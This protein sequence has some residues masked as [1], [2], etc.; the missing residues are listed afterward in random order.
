[1][2]RPNS[3]HLQMQLLTTIDT[4]PK[5]QALRLQEGW[6]ATFYY[7]FFCRIDEQ[8]YAVLYSE[9]DSRPNIPVNVLVALEALK[10]G[11]NWS[12]EEIFDAFCFDL[13]V[14]FALGYRNLD[15][16]QFDLRTVY[17]FR[18]R[19]GEHMQKTGVN[20][21][22]KSFEQVTDEQID[23]FRLKTGR[24]RMDSSEIASNIRNMSRL[25]L[26]VEVI[27]RVHRMLNEDDRERYAQTFAPYT[28]GTSGQYVYRVKGEDGPAHMQRIGELMRELLEKLA[29]AYGEQTTYQMLQRVFAEHFLVEQDRLRL[30]VGKEL[31]AQSLNSPDD[32]EATFRKKNNRS[33]KGYVANVTETCDPDNPLQLIAKVQTKPNVANDDDMLVEAI[34]SLKERLGIEEVHTDGGYNSDESFKVLRDD[35]IELIQTAIRGHSPHEHLGLDKF[36]IATSAA[37]NTEEAGSDTLEDGSIG[38]SEPATGECNVANEPDPACGMAATSQYA[39]P[40]K[41]VPIK[42]TCP[43]GQTVEIDPVESKTEYKRYRAH[44]DTGQCAT[45]P[46]KDKCLAREVKSGRHRTLSFDERD[47]EIARRRRRIAQDQDAGTNLRVA[48]ESTIASLKQPFNYDQ[49]PVRGM[50]RV[51]MVLLGCAAMVNVRRI[52]RYISRKGANEGPRGAATVTGNAREG[53]SSLLLCSASRM[54]RILV[55]PRPQSYAY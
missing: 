36:D 52:H 33:Y 1:M 44:F 22:E 32:T 16:G 39:S 4:L 40:A 30:K 51:G 14:R 38:A 50:F 29:A 3:K 45:C 18:H 15:E 7:E 21:I 26:L 31:S 5:Q 2:F 8:P 10:S 24:V 54:L 42:I 13:Q 49:L 20:L 43:H 12:D 41:G 11:F 6:A 9:K 37:D 55:C 25:H 23:A 17:N 34:P 19:L 48:I 27:Q 35:G 47:V 53:E 46:F 28:K